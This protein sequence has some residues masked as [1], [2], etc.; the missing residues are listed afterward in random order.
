[1]HGRWR[2]VGVAAV[3]VVAALGA[4]AVPAAASIGSPSLTLSPGPAP[5]GSTANLGADIGFRP[6]GGDSPKDLTL[7]LPP[8]LIA[9]AAI[10]GG[11]CL[12]SAAPVAACQVGTGTVTATAAGLPV[13]LTLN[14]VFD[15]VAPP[16]PGDLAGLVVQ[17]AAPVTNQLTPLGSPAAVTLRPS[18]SPA[19]VGLN[20]AFTSIPDT[21]DG[22]PIS[23]SAI[24]STF[25]GLRF[26]SSCPA[27]P[28]RLVVSADSYQD[29]TDVTA[30][31][32]LP[33]TGCAGE[34]FEPAFSVAAVRDAA[35]TGVQITTTVTQ[36][37]A[38][39]TAGRLALALPMSVVE[40]DAESVLKY[41]LICP[42][43][44]S[45]T[46]RPIGSAVAISPLYPAP[47]TGT[48][49][50]T[51]QLFAPAVTIT[52]PSPFPI[53]LNGT[54]NLG[55]NTTTF[56]G[57]PDIPLS[58]LRVTLDGGPAAGFLATCAA[59]TGTAT[60]TLTTQDGDRS[61]A[62]PATF[63][64]ADCVPPAPFTGGV[65]RSRP[66]G[67]TRGPALENVAL[68]GL[69]RD[70]PRLSFRLV[71]GR[72]RPA[73]TGFVI[74]APSGL[75]FTEHRIHGRRRVTGVSLS[76]GR[77]RSA[78]V[79]HGRLVVALRRSGGAVGV[80]ITP[81][82][83]SE[84]RSLARRVRRGVVARL[85]LTVTVRRVRGGSRTLSLQL[86]R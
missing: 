86:R 53:T 37:G 62:L 33:V 15:L 76:G 49:Y 50:L 19:G 17:V 80:R 14:A 85:K 43:P 23:L 6:S 1:M 61:A 25:D 51:G 52:F 7:Q 64:V 67:R 18:G 27:T 82:A 46:C 13:P 9:N 54:L 79:R 68:A 5:A 2:R 16:S 70:R 59:P 72:G 74:S 8:G 4:G 60:A 69:T 30:S 55:T 3:T 66:S 57:I 39:A 48:V 73:L 42:R 34:R 47:L 31:A 12:K 63:T 40:P 10:D 22:L 77:I 20:I 36:A 32:P 35:D 83:L 78:Q 11:A 81:S 29:P 24:N 84:T 26:P 56:P 28:A 45:G 58:N 41:G 38:Q 75:R 65:G 71:A 44:A 21:F